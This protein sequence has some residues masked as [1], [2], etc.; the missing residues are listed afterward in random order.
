M[1]IR[2]LGIGIVAVTVIAACAG[3]RPDSLS[4]APGTHFKYPT[5]LQDAEKDELGFEAGEIF[6]PERRSKDSG[7]V[8]SIPYYRFA[9]TAERPATPI[10]LLAGGP[11][12]SWI[13]YFNEN[14]RA[15]QQVRF[16]RSI[17]DVV[18]FDQRGAGHSRPSLHCPQR[19]DLPLNRVLE[20]EELASALRTAAMACRKHWIEA[21]VDLDSYNTLE[22]AADVNDLRK[23]L[24]YDAISLIGGSYGSHLALAL[25]RDYPDVVERIVLD[26]IEG[27]DHTYDLPSAV[28]E[29]LEK[30]AH[31]AEESE[32][33][34]EHVPEN[35]LMAVLEDILDA[36]EENP[37]TVSVD[38]EGESVS[39]KIGRTSIQDVVL[40]GAQNRTNLAWAQ[41][42]LAMHHG[43]LARPARKAIEVRRQAIGNAMYFAMDCA[44]G[45]SRDREE[46]IRTD[47][48]EQAAEEILGNRN[49]DYFATCDAWNVLDLGAAFR[50][51]VVSDVPALLFQ[52][53]WDVSTPY[54]NAAEVARSLSNAILVTVKG[55]AHSTVDDLFREWSGMKALME[56]FLQGAPVDPPL[57]I[58]LTDAAFYPPKS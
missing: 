23:A 55:G 9:A 49:I 22:N 57:T 20:E 21:G 46:R 53:T 14:R 25:V 29:A 34:R 32:Q 51:D 8:L 27:P 15:R 56:T 1:K 42:V 50:D 24:G 13:D 37:Q 2:N 36:L 5:V 35:G 44:S 17:A 52:G 58:D 10:F 28:L 40:S 26:G 7:R 48:D 54:I 33:V 11:G 6:V 18:V 31:A 39:V 19:L 41:R 43:D 4:P 47:P 16:L 30:I 45:I 12:I 38:L 3:D